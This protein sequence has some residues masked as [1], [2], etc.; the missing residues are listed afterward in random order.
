MLAL[1][2]ALAG[3]LPQEKVHK[4]KRTSVWIQELREG[5]WPSDRWRAAQAIGEIGPEARRAIPD[6]IQA[7]KNPDHLVRWAAAGALG[8]FGSEARDAVPSLRDL[9]ARDPSPAVRDAAEESLRQIDQ[10]GS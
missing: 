3:C 5:R 1:A 10:G 7:L 8:R 4:G 2:V 6:L 9:A